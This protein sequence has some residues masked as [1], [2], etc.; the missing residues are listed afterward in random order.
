RSKDLLRVKGINVSPVEV[1]NILA[2]HPAVDVAYVVGLPADGLDQQVVALI[3]LRGDGSLPE[4][5]LREVAARELSHYKRPSH[6]I[7][8]A[9]DEIPLGGTAKPQREALA[10]LA[11]SRLAHGA[12]AAR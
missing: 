10:G 11:A 8:V 3:V 6:Y 4:E 9:R 5:E 7:A 12:R 1:E 2:T